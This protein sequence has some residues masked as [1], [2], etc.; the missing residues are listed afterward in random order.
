MIPAVSAAE[1]IKNP[2][3]KGDGIIDHAIVIS[4]VDVHSGIIRYAAHSSPRTYQS[5]EEGMK[6]YDNCRVYIVKIKNDAE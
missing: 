1:E 3:S 2:L 6:G 5:L 4:N